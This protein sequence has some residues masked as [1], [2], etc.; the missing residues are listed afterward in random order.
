MYVRLSVDTLATT[1]VLGYSSMDLIFL[2]TRGKNI[3]LEM[4][5]GVSLKK[6]THIE[7]F[8]NFRKIVILGLRE[9]NVM[10]MTW[11]RRCEK[12][13]LKKKRCGKDVVRKTLSKRPCE[14]ETKTWE[15]RSFDRFHRSSIWI[16][17]VIFNFQLLLK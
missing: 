3:S 16:S 4:F 2:F 9:E 14:K 10:R 7:I 17:Y 6:I 12:D 15:R 1:R 8:A 13:A 11:E 5:V